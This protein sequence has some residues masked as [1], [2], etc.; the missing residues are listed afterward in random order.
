VQGLSNLQPVNVS[1]IF[2]QADALNLRRTELENERRE[3]RRKA[4]T[5]AIAA[6][7]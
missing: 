6:A 7:F 3:K 5:G 1:G 4:I 2:Q